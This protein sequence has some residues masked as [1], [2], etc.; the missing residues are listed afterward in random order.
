M[1]GGSDT[2]CL[3][4][5]RF[6][7]PSNGESF[8]SFGADAYAAS[9]FKLQSAACPIATNASFT[10][11]LTACHS[12]I[13]DDCH[14]FVD[15]FTALGIASLL[16][17]ELLLADTDLLSEQFHQVGCANVT[18]QL[19][20]LKASSRNHRPDLQ[21]RFA[22]C[23]EAIFPTGFVQVEPLHDDVLIADQPEDDVVSLM[24]RAF[25][26]VY[27]SSSTDSDS[28]LNVNPPSSPSSEIGD[29]AWKSVHIYDLRSNFVHGRVR[30]RPHEA[31]F[32]DA[33]RLLGYSH[34]DVASIVDVNPAPSDL[35]GLQVSPLLL[36]CHDDLLFGDTR[37]AVLIDT[38]VHGEAFDSTVETDR[39]TTLLP[40]RVTRAFLLR[41]VGVAS[42]CQLQADRCLV[43]LR[44]ALLPLQSQATYAL[45]HGYY[46]RI[47]IPPFD[48]PP[49]PTPFAIRACQAGL[50]RSQLIDR[51]Q[52]FGDNVD[53]LHSP[54]QSDQEDANFDDSI[55]QLLQEE[56]E[57]AALLQTQF[58]TVPT[59]LHDTPNSIGVYQDLE[60]QCSFTEE[61]LQAVNVFRQTQDDLAEAETIPVDLTDQSIFVQQLFEALNL[62]QSDNSWQDAQLHVE[63]WFSDHVNFRTSHFTR[64]VALG[65]LVRF[66]EQQLRLRWLDYVDPLSDV[67]FVL[68]HPLPEDVE[69]GVFVQIILVQHP[70]SRF[71]SSVV[72]IYD[73][74]YDNGAPHSSAIVLPDRVSLSVV[75]AT[76]DFGSLC[77]PEQPFNDCTLWFGSLEI[78]PHQQVA[79]RHGYAFGLVVQRPQEVDIRALLALG[80]D[81]L[82]HSLAEVLDDAAAAGS[83]ASA[84]RAPV[85]PTE[86]ITPIDDGWRPD[87]FNSVAERFRLFGLSAGIVHTWFLNGQFAPQC[88]HSRQVALSDDSTAWEALLVAAWHDHADV[89][90]P[91]FLHFVDPAPPG[92]TSTSQIGHVII[93][94]LPLE[95][96]A[97]V[98]LAR[99]LYSEMA[100]STTILLFTHQIDYL[101]SL[102]EL[103]WLHR[104]KPVDSNSKSG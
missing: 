40:A 67:E 6:R 37:Q 54:L 86:T 9:C 30:I 52:R 21:I 43:W 63:T 27:Q 73:S 39:F 90:L 13:W 79:A 96:Y 31:A 69:R 91:C 71:C 103:S 93:V 11:T 46:I 89:Q 19:T 101:L 18:P 20:C 44:G 24:G 4:E 77:P 66:W 55:R 80:D 16:H 22:T 47:A 82:R 25:G 65:P 50:S 53:S 49:I 1:N 92:A 68:V 83:R 45:Q 60:P 34:H 62:D 94:Q 97:A 104:I 29:R 102:F 35:A 57:E 64:T 88:P 99:N 51:F 10:T 48:Q 59:F 23:A 56:D 38:E 81:E 2:L 76:V 5:S 78:L 32:I 12:V 33:R 26:H 95:N 75:T 61:F 100:L 14:G 17:G 74:A 72:T 70:L 3:N 84:S 28:E 8:V 85:M 42:Y 87:W 15:T 7:E 58:C 41:I 98:L 36:L